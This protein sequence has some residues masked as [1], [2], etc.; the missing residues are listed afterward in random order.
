MKR[1]FI[2]NLSKHLQELNSIPCLNA[3]GCG[4]VALGIYNLLVKLKFK[5]KIVSINYS[6]RDTDLVNL[7]KNHNVLP[8]DELDS[9]LYRLF[10]NHYIVNVGKFYFDSRTAKDFPSRE[11][12]IRHFNM[13]GSS[14]EEILK[15]DLIYHLKYGVW[16]PSFNKKNAE[17]IRK[18][19]NNYA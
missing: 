2:D 10:S 13:Y 15:V 11:D 19:I 16:N 1:S 4:F 17:K 14:M 9:F 6:P 18:H 7:R 5:P 8:K 12:A 3:G